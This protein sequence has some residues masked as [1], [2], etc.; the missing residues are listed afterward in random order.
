MKFLNAIYIK[1]NDVPPGATKFWATC[2][3]S[4]GKLLFR[5]DCCSFE[6]LKL[7]LE[8]ELFNIGEV[9]VRKSFTE[10]RCK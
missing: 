3:N 2:R 8:S 6:S 10:L 9:A 5:V 4:D 7:T 1:Y